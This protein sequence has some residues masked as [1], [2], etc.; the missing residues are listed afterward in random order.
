MSMPDWLLPLLALTAIVGFIGFAF[1]QGTKVKPS[2]DRHD[3]WTGDGV[4]HGPG[5]DGNH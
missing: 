4:H 3:A 1:R 2:G 5:G